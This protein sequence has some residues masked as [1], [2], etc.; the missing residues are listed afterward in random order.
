MKQSRSNLRKLYSH[1]GIFDACLQNQLRRDLQLCQGRTLWRYLQR[2]SAPV[3]P[4]RRRYSLSR[5]L[6][7]QQGHDS[8]RP[9]QTLLQRCIFEKLT[10]IYEKLLNFSNYKFFIYWYLIINS[11]TNFDYIVQTHVS[12]YFLFGRNCFSPQYYFS[13]VKIIY[14]FYIN[15]SFRG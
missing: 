8:C 2:C 5:T 14:Q 7:G 6:L 13:S 10:Q 4:P 12:I 11:S 9:H 1:F 3:K 15:I